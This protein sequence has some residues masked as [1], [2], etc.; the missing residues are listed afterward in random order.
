MTDIA[1]LERR[2]QQL[3][4]ELVEEPGVDIDDDLYLLYPAKDASQSQGRVI[5]RHVD[6][7]ARRFLRQIAAQGK[8]RIYREIGLEN[9]AH[10][11]ARIKAQATE[12]GAFWSFSRGHASA[13]YGPLYTGEPYLLTA[14][15]KPDVVEWAETFRANL[16]HVGEREVHV[17]GRVHL[18]C[19]AN[20][21]GRVVFRP[22]RQ[23]F[24]A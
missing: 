10:W 22:T 15:A 16:A 24:R 21:E 8:L 3:K 17:T 9:A 1:R 19:V 12:L 6:H 20:P 11:L 4:A 2:F 5:A 13:D 7:L 14:D 18:L 23:H